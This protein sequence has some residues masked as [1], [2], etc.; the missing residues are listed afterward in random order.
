MSTLNSSLNKLRKMAPELNKAADDAAKI[1]QDVEATL[2][3]LNIGIPAEADVSGVSKTKA[4][5]EYVLLA[6]RRVKSNFRIAIVVERHT[7]FV[8]SEGF[9]DSAEETVS[10]TPWLE[11]PRDLKLE[12]F[13][14]LPALLEAIIK[15]ATEAK[16]KVEKAQE[17]I[18]QIFASSSAPGE[19]FW[20]HYP[21]IA[22]MPPCG[23]CHKPMIEGQDAYSANN[24]GPHPDSA[25]ICAACFNKKWEVLRRVR[26]NTLVVRSRSGAPQK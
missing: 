15:N 20:E 22:G 14:K 17:T 1:V 2:T 8:N 19:E 11:C 6:Y 12:S 26:G 18:K 9:Q 21:A 5:T 7:E 10:E 23:E 16:E 25:S 24:P 13:P 3:Q 4:V